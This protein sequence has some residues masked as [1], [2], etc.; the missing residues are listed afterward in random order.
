MEHACPER[1]MSIEQGTVFRES[2]I[3]LRRSFVGDE[4][5]ERCFE[6]CLIW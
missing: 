6:R 4:S 1:E 3:H 5:L 2:P